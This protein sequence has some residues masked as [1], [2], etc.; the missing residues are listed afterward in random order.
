M[1]TAT[2]NTG[3]RS[4]PLTLPALLGATTLPGRLYSELESAI[5]RGTLQPGERLHADDLAKHF[6]VS[7]IPI[8]EALSSLGQAGWVEIKPRHGVHVRE[9]TV[10]EL[11]ELF[12]FRADVEALVARWAAERRTDSDLVN[13]KLAVE[14]TRDAGATVAD[15][16]GN[17]FIGFREALRQ[18]AHNSVLAATSASLEKRAR[19]YFSTVQDQLGSDW[20]Q[21]EQQVLDY[22]VAGDGEKAAALTGE[23]IRDTGVAV[24]QIL[25][26]NSV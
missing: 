5:I 3:R 23:H 17:G 15:D 25:F 13:L 20:V 10:V 21:L 1:T 18:A 11:N 6:G 12:D 26:G 14:R 4:L 9:R 24:H 19:F 2:Q 16:D 7:R 8:R 22:V